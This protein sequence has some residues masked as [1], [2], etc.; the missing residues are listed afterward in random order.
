MVGGAAEITQ[1]R[2]RQGIF[3]GAALAFIERLGIRFELQAAALDQGDVTP[4]VAELARQR[5]PGG[6]G[7]DDGDVGLDHRALGQGSSVDEHGRQ[8]RF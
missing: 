7:A 2:F 4:A 5:D 8:I 6:A 1:P 3:D